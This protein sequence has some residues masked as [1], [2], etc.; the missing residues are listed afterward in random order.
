MTTY[1]APICN[2]CQHYDR[3]PLRTANTCAAFPAGIPQAIQLSQVDHRQPIDG[4]QGIVFAPV[5]AEAAAYAASLFSA[6][7]E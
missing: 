3:N 5:D 1:A 4:D 7:A 6:E 2:F